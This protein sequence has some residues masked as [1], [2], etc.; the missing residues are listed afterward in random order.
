MVPLAIASQIP[1]RGDER[2]HAESDDVDA[3][4]ALS[5]LSASAS[6]AT[7]APSS[8]IGARP[9]FGTRSIACPF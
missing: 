3:L 2:A 6:R 9:S 4:R 1:G 7:I 8:A 5:R